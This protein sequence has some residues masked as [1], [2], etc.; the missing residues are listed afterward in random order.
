MSNIKFLVLGP[1]I[2][3]KQGAGGAVV[4]FE[5]L[6]EELDLAG[7]SYTLIDTNKNNY[8]RKSLSILNI[9]YQYILLRKKHDVVFFNS[10]R[11]YIYLLPLFL[12][13]NIISPKKIALRKFGG[14][15][16]QDL[17][18]PV[19]GAIIKSLLKRLDV[20]FVES[21]LLL[22][23]VKKYNVNTHWFPNVRK[24]N[25][26][27]GDLNTYN[28]QFAFISHIKASKGVNELLNAF[29]DLDSSYCLHFYGAVVEPALLD[30]ITSTPN[31][32]YKGQ[33]LPANV[34]DTINKYD[35]IVLP[36]YYAGEGYPGILIEAYAC[37][38]PVISTNWKQVPEIVDDGST[39]YLITP[40]SIT[41]LKAAIT[42]I[43]ND[44]YQVLRK[45][46]IVKFYDF[47]SSV[48]SKRIFKTLLI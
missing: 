9:V 16:D 7:L 13:F 48:V 23:A 43:N 31:I 8:R 1:R 40:R 11:D 29:K 33:V 37:G 34:Y 4:L 38:K 2:N 20:L 35:V 21:K 26:A 27:N 15:L 45:N 6:I 41:E 10:S 30:L 25:T 3:H 47:D 12:F 17:T 14:E 24:K 42:K 46:A 36:T 28:K 22:N 5:N 44:N 19:K 32:E 18:K 39:G